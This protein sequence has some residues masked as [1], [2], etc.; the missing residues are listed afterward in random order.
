[1]IQPGAVPLGRQVAYGVARAISGDAHY[2]LG[3]VL[4]V[5]T[6]ASHDQATCICIVCIHVYIVCTHVY[7][8]CVYIYIL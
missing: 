5:P 7:I 8:V 6:L 2:T 1:M 4:S 3:D